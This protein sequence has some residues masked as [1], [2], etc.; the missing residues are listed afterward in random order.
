MMIFLTVYSVVQIIKINRAYDNLIES[1]S[2]QYGYLSDALETLALLRL[3]NVSI[4]YQI[5]ED[6][7]ALLYSSLHHH[8]YEALCDQFLGYLRS[9]RANVIGDN[10]MTEEDLY[11]RLRNIA[12]AE[13]SFINR[14]LSVLS[15]IRT[16]VSLKDKTRVKDELEISFYSATEMTS[17]LDFLRKITFEYVETESERITNYS[18]R[19]ARTQYMVAIAIIIA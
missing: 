1:T 8:D 4:A 19:I 13:S 18:K 5:N 12:S 6:E 3:N 10:S 17:Q 16:G 15:R 9:Y 7:I 11:L 14:F 2:R